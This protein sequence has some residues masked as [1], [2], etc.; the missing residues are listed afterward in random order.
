MVHQGDDKIGMSM[1]YI[2]IMIVIIL[3]KNYK[4]TDTKV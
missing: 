3:L 4:I 2:D 1:Y